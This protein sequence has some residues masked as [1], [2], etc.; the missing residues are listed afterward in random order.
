[1]LLFRSES[2][3][4]SSADCKSEMYTAVSFML[5]HMS[6][7]LS[8]SGKKTSTNFRQEDWGKK[9]RGVNNIGMEETN[10]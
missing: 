1:M 4:L 2:L 9:F 7:N 8:F 6:E 10:L 5:F 3:V